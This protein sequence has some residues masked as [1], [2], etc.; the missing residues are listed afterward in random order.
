MIDLRCS[1]RSPARR[2]FTLV[3]LLVVIG[4]IALLISILLPSLSHAREQAKAVQ[5][6]SNL[7]QVGQAVHI[8]VNQ[9]KG[10]LSRWSNSTNWQNPTN[11]RE[12]IDPTDYAKAY[13]GV[14]YAV[15]AKLPKT[16]FHCPSALLGQN[17]DGMTF[18]EGAI[19][20]SYAQNCY[21][22]NNSGFS[23][24]RRTTLFGNPNEITLF[25]RIDY[26]HGVK[27]W[28]GR[29]LSRIRHSSQ[30]IF[31]N[32]GYESVTDGNGDTFN[33]WHQ[34]VKPDRTN[35]YLRHNKKSNVLFVDSHVEGLTRQQLSDERY[36]TGRW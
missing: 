34:W 36:Y 35:E 15:A 13:W 3:E 26:G 5:C 20:T 25:I 21:G 7:R 8:Y 31:A 16:L 10:F 17:G 14:A 28:Q 33:D 18:N 23:D 6:A 30:T 4:I 27:I 19:Y 2:G 32:D 29:K 11:K 24:T 22:G 12:M 9:N 1:D